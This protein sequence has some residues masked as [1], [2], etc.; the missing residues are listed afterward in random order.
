LLHCRIVIPL[1][2]QIVPVLA[3]DGVLLERV[4]A[5]LLR[6]V[7]GQDIK[8][9]L[10]E[11]LELLLKA[12]LTVSINLSIVSGRPFIELSGIPFHL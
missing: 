4:D 6:K 11:D 2:V 12:L 5:D 8:I 3:V 9:S 1:L 10:V 7:D